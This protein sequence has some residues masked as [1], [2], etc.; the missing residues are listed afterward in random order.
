MAKKVKKAEKPPAEKPKLNP[1]QEAFC[2]YYAQ[3]EGTFGNATLSYSAAYEIELGDLTWHDKDGNLRVHKDFVGDYHVCSVNGARL[4]RNADVQERINV[5]LNEL[6]QDKIVDAELAKV[7][8]QDGDL[9]PKVAAI[10][11]YNKLR[12]RIVDLS[13]VTQVQKLDMDDVRAVIAVLPKERQD[14]FYATITDILAEAELL[15]S[16]GKAQVNNS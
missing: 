13:K 15:R 16:S 3:G 8:K 11:E 4:L 1:Q 7:I 9:T 2:R 6:L 14:Q 5:L 10:K 12:G